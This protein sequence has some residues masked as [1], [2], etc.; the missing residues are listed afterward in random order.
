MSALSLRRPALAVLCAFVGLI[1]ID[2]FGAVGR[3]AGQPSVGPTGAAQYSIPLWTAPGTN[4]LQPSLALVYSSS[5]GNGLLGMGWSIAGLSSIARCNQTPAQDGA[6]NAASLL[7]TDKLC[8]DGSRLR[9]VSGIYGSA[10]S[11]YRTEIETFSL[12]TANGTQGNGPAWFEVKAKDGLIYEYGNSSSSFINALAS[13][14]GQ[15]SSARAWALSR[16]RDRSHNY[17]EF[18][19][20]EDTTNGGYRPHEIHW[21]GNSL[22]GALPQYKVAFVYEGVARPDTIWGYRFGDSSGVDGKQNETKRLDRIDV[23][24]GTI[25]CVLVRS[26]DVAYESPGGAG[27]RSRIDWIQEKGAAGTDSFPATQVSWIDGSA[28][29]NASETN[30]SQ[31]I[32]SGVTPMI[33]DISGDGRDDVVW[34]TSAT[35]GSGFWA[36]MVANSSGGFDS[37]ATT[38]I[39]NT[40]FAQALPIQWDGDDKWDILVPY[41]GGTWWVLRGTGSAAPGGLALHA[42]TTVSSTGM[43]WVADVDGEGRGDLL[44]GSNTAGATGYCEIRVRFA[45]SVRI[46]R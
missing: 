4:G 21:T 5:S 45:R 35:S 30:T 31:S 34:S 43:F 17:V 36:Y 14:G 27:N 24:H 1:A 28:G 38:T 33:M 2:A 8:L 16:I 25:T 32:P 20:T 13:G 44:R 41:A 23:C 42:D 15:V 29:W 39:P 6:W 11:T 3:T 18:F 46:Q 19:Y 9:L 22:T 26:Y 40:G 37:I 12:V 10:G 7:S